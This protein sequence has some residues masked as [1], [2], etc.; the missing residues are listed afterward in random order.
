M[1]MWAEGMLWKTVVGG[2]GAAGAHFC[3][4]PSSSQPRVRIG[5]RWSAC[6][7]WV[8]EIGWVVHIKDRVH[9][10][11]QAQVLGLRDDSLLSVLLL[12]QP[13]ENLQTAPIRKNSGLGGAAR[14]FQ[15]G[16]RN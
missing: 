15:C 5:A 11:G 2:R 14:D 3:G 12:R 4:F 10:P 8:R 16:G 7:H 1:E 9:E 6:I 13:P